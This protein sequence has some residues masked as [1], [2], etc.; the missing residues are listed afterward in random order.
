M[1][2]I[3]SAKL[4]LLVI[5]LSLFLLSPLAAENYYVN[6]VTG[7]DDN[8]G[9]LVLANDL[10]PRNGPFKTIN[11]ALKLAVGGDRIF[12]QNTNTPYQECL[13]IQGRRHSG[14]MI[15]PLTIVSDGAILDGTRPINDRWEYYRDNIYRFQ[16]ELKSYQQLYFEGRPLPQTRLFEGDQP[17]TLDENQWTL[18]DGWIYFKTDGRDAIRY[19]MSYCYHQTGITLYEVRNVVIDGLIVQGFQLDGVNAHDLVYGTTV[20]STISRGNGRS[21]ISIGGASRVSVVACL[22]GE[23][24]KAQ[25]RSEGYSRSEVTNTDIVESNDY[26]VPFEQSRGS[27]VDFYE[28]PSDQ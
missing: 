13:T 9:Q 11:H 4:C 8:N 5:V 2:K 24:G 21:G 1:T 19:D 22:L 14:S 23:N 7:D 18:H 15:N 16:P 25:L 26:G 20:V 10:N 3:R 17:D 27:I 12:I 28:E 6:N